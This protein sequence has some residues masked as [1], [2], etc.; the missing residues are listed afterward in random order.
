MLFLSFPNIDC[1]KAGNT[2]KQLQYLV[3]NIIEIFGEAFTEGSMTKIVDSRPLLNQAVDMAYR[4]K[5]LYYVKRLH[6]LVTKQQKLLSEMPST[7]SGFLS[8]K[9]GLPKNSPCFNNM[10]SNEERQQALTVLDAVSN[11]LVEKMKSHPSASRGAKQIL[12]QSIAMIAG[13]FSRK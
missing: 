8:P 2:K 5:N 11:E 7:G 1:G 12:K 6:A 9:A 10:L 3:K 13:I 4:T